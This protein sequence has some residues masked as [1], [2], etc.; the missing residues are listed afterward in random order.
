LSK[1]RKLEGGKQISTSAVKRGGDCP[2]IPAFSF[3]YLT[4]NSS[5]NLE[6]FSDPNDKRTAIENVYIRLVEIG[7]RNWLY[8]QQQGK[9]VGLELLSAN[10]ISFS[11]SDIKLTPDE[12]IIVF[13]VKGYAGK[14]SRIL[15]IREDGCPI[16][17]IIG[18]DFDFSAYNH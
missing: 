16:L 11:P 15:G 9:K 8:W 3:A 6:Y 18:Y 4:N 12:K 17:H 5:H 2:Q 10:E 7:K 13:R 14:D 1:L